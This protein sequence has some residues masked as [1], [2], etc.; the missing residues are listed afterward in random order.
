VKDGRVRTLEE[1]YLHS[2]PVKE[3]QIIDHFLGENLKDEVMKITPV[4]KQTAAGQRTKFKACV[5]VG[6]FN[7]HI[8]LGVKCANEVAGAIR[9]A[10]ISAKMSVV[11]VRR[12]YWG[13]KFGQ[14]HTVPI[15]VTGKCGSVR[16]RL[17][18]APRGT[19]IVAARATKKVLNYAGLKDCYTGSQGNSKTLFNFVKAAVDALTNT[20]QYLTPDFWVAQPSVPAPFQ[21]HSDFLKETKKDHVVKRQE[22][23]Q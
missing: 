17:V 21:T 10:L 16:V 23:G 19:G 2:L 12:G 4:Q 14:P 20:Y 6:D 5:I 1:V 9:G 7:G 11:P 22:R 13:G 15:K 18:P 8:G 3:F